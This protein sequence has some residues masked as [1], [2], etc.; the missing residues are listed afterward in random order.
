MDN[1][2]TETVIKRLRENEKMTQEELTQKIFAT[3]KAVSK[4]E[5]SN[6]GVCPLC[7]C[8]SRQSL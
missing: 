3:S 6:L 8:K 4:W 2:V 5:T 7:S 1:Y